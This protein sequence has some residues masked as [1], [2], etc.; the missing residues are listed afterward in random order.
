MWGDY[1]GSLSTVYNDEEISIHEQFVH[2]HTIHIF[3]EGP[4]SIGQT[5]TSVIHANST[6]QTII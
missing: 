5:F 1:R 4:L 2:S 6:I 3:T